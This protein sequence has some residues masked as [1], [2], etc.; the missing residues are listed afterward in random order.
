[1]RTIVAPTLFGELA[2]DLQQR[3]LAKAPLRRFAHQQMIQQRGEKPQGFWV[4]ESGKV[5]VGVF[6]LKGEFR[7]IALLS[8]GDSYGE[9]A[10]FAGNRR[11]VDALADG[12]VTLR[13]IDSHS[14]E[15]AIQ[16]DPAAM[17]SLVTTLSKQLQELLGLLASLSNGSA[18]NRI[19]A[20][21]VTLVRSAGPPSR[22]TDRR[23]AIGQQ[24]LA[25]LAGLTRATVNTCLRDMESG[26]AIRRG[27]RQVTITDLEKLEALA[28]T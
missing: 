15:S 8:T 14:F 3:L 9:L 13:W 18:T 23:L 25:E 2:H 17:R 21:L 27:Y 26:G 12:E 22:G 6:G 24:E 16:A 19:A 20:T 11:A 4:I 10:V 5:R 1:M 28:L 7:A